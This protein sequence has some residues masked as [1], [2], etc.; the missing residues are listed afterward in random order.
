[1]LIG[2]HLESRS[3]PAI[4]QALDSM[5]AAYAARRFTVSAM[6]FDGE[7]ALSTLTSYIQSK[8]IQVNTTAKNEHVPDIERA[9]RTIKERVRAF[10][11]TLPYKLSQ[12][13]VIYLVYYC[14]SAINMTPKQGSA[15]GRV[16]PREVFLGRKLDY[17]K[18]MK[19]SFGDYAQVHQDD[20]ITNTMAERTVGALA[21]GP[22][23]NIQGGYRFLNLATWKPI[24]RRKWTAL[25][26]PQHV[27]DHV[28]LKSES[29][30][31]V[32]GQPTVRVGSGDIEDDQYDEQPDEEVQQPDEAQ[33]QPPVQFEELVVEEQDAADVAGVEEA[34][35]QPL[36]DQDD[37]GLLEP[38]MPVVAEEQ[39]S[40]DA[41]VSEPPMPVIAE[42]Q[43]SVE[44]Q[45]ASEI[46][47]LYEQSRYNLRPKRQPNWQRH[48]VL[49]NLSVKKGIKE[50]G[51][52]ALL[53]IMKEL[54]Q[55][56][57]KKVFHPIYYDRAKMPR[58]IRSHLFLKQKRDMTWKGR[59]VADG[60]QQDRILS[61]DTSS[62]T[63]S[64]E[65][66]FLTAALDALEHRHVVTVDIEGAYL[67]ADMTTNVFMEISS[68]LSDILCSMYPQVYSQY[69]NDRGKLYVVLDKA[70]YGCIESAKLF[71]EHLS[72]TLLSMGFFKNPYDHCV[73][74][75][76]VYGKQ[77]TI[78]THVD[79]LKISCLDPRGVKD[80]LADLTKAYRNLNVHDEKTLDYLGMIFDY[81]VVGEVRISMDNM[82]R[83]AVN[84]Y[85][86]QS[87]A[88]TPAALHLYQINNSSPLLRAK[89]KE[90]FHSVVQKLLYI[91]KRTRPDILTA[92]SFLTTRVREPTEEDE[93]K[94]IKVLQYL[95]GTLDL[96]LTLTGSEDMIVTA[97]IDAS[98]AVHNDCKGQT[99]VAISVGKGTVYAKSSKQKLVA[100]SSTEAE[101]IGVSDGLSQALWTRNFLQAQ[102]IKVKPVNLKQDNK[103]T[104]CMV[105]KG[106]STSPRTRHVA[107]RYFFVKDRMEKGEVEIAYLPTELMV[108]DF[109]TKP[110]QG[111][112]FR[113][114]RAE[115]LNLSDG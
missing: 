6:M 109:F 21:L 73:F 46:Q 5:L 114:L 66:L 63:V 68:E 79:D 17:N 64:T 105:E 96:T 27:I 35:P 102:G 94:L 61:L 75:K 103:S 98:Y 8:G 97:Y 38:P 30:K 10:W 67:H 88:A 1:M 101:L 80:T 81:S 95:H 104:I 57:K 11:N 32:S 41:G 59:M 89:T 74:N 54:D 13:L 24:T 58:A 39:A 50:F 111:E 36:R 3:V 12:I 23:G 48:M 62:P 82:I 14:I 20:I 70:L 16:S 55:L 106:K 87:K 45:V 44:E 15:F 42:E 71:Y 25:P 28:N 47:A 76:E 52:P 93:K 113:R 100:K 65:A 4:R 2:K 99:G 19:L 85:N 26:V 69:V 49:T 78:T 22:M 83:E 9:G 90:K 56:H 53:A 107:I 34:Q 92:V 108:A 51:E 29:D 77:C 60:S 43:A 115:V 33:P 84:E 86:I 110:L 40:D 37:A 18:D 31:R 72:A 7:G 112:L 91:S